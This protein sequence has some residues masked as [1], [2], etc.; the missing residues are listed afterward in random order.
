[1]NINNTTKFGTEMDHSSSSPSFPTPQPIMIRPTALTVIAQDVMKDVKPSSVRFTAMDLD[2]FDHAREMRL[3]SLSRLPDD[4]YKKSLTDINSCY[5]KLPVDSPKAELPDLSLATPVPIISTHAPVVIGK[6]SPTI[7]LED[8]RNLK[9]RKVENFNKMT[10]SQNS[11]EALVSNLPQ[12]SADEYK[13]TLKDINSHCNQMAVDCSTAELPQNKTKNR[14]A[15]IK[16][17]DTHRLQLKHTFKGQDYINASAVNDMII[18]QGPLSTVVDGFWL[19]AFE[20]NC[21]IVCLTNAAEYNVQRQ[22]MIEKTF[23][24]WEQK[25][26]EQGNT[27]FSKVLHTD[28]NS[29]WFEVKYLNEETVVSPDNQ[30]DQKITKRSFE[31]TLGNE[32][33][34][35]TQWHFENWRDFST[36][37]PEKLAELIRLIKECD[38]EPMIHCSAG[39]GRS[40]ALAVSLELINDYLQ[41]G[42]LPTHEK[43]K[44]TIIEFRKARP[45]MV[46]T[47]EQLELIG[48]TIKT[49]FKGK[50]A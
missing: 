47:A 50:Q 5:K 29:L 34:V 40:G 27:I 43:I 3:L 8:N 32:S 2:D 49:Y 38:G 10:I 13:N 48:T 44:E 46:Q 9:R 1:M 12:L 30:C 6:R 26:P 15:N 39:V 7:D 11:Y 20:N 28:D 18:A 14:Y 21:Q 45:G 17:A 4:D 25:Y 42:Q 16:P 33:K 19:A 31:I 35:V 36:C 41:Y 24:Y 23:P 22:Q 37:N